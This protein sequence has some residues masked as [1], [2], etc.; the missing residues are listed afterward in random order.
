MC[1]PRIDRI[2][3]VLSQEFNKNSAIPTVHNT[4]QAYLTSCPSRL[5]LAASHASA[6]SYSL[7]V[8]LVRGAYNNS[9]DARAE[10]TGVVSPIWGS[11]KET[12]ACFDECAKRLGERIKEE[13]ENEG[14]NATS[15]TGVLYATHNATSVRKVLE[16]LLENGLAKEGKD[17]KIVIDERLRGKVGFAQLMGKLT[18]IR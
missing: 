17:R 6:N 4:Y 15:G 2:V 16:G 11:K 14:T 3:N 5:A 13:V 1:L 10:L 12:D 18:F 8:K 7:G 9:E